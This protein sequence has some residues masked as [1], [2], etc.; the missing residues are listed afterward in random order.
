M[1]IAKRHGKA[2]S[3]NDFVQN[4]FMV[5]VMNDAG[6]LCITDLDFGLVDYVGTARSTD[7]TDKRPGHGPGAKQVMISTITRLRRPGPN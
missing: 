5:W 3:Y 7:R 1:A 6:L 2:I 4:A